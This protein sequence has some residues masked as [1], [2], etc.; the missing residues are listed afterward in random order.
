LSS[1]LSLREYIEPVKS[2]EEDELFPAR[3]PKINWRGF[4]IPALLAGY[5]AVGQTAVI[6]VVPD[7]DSFVRSMAPTSNYGAAGALSVSGSV[8]VNG[9]GQQNGLFDTLMRFPMSNV[10]A[11][12]DG[13]FGAGNWVV[14]KS[15]LIVNEMASPENAIFNRGV[16]AYEVSWI[17]S[18]GWVE[19]TGTPKTPTTDGVT[20]NDLPGIMNSNLDVS[21]GT[22]TNAGA[23]G[24]IAFT[25][26]LADAFVT[27][28]RQG[29]EVGL[30]LAAASPGVGFT[31][32][33]RDFG[34]TN[35][36]PL[37]EIT[38]SIAPR[39]EGIVLSN[40]FVEVS[41]GR[42]SNWTYRLQAS[43]SLAPSGAIHWND[44]M[45]VSAPSVA[46][47]VTYR[48]GVTNRQ[49]FYRLS[50]SP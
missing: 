7:A 41:F 8:A 40:G 31:F 37:L 11:S 22:F 21:L 39:I 29:G 49:R 2:K 45:S 10:V 6:S 14:A 44:I 4:A 23:D 48:D 28:I 36:K 3:A 17:S 42:V 13:A 15:R 26:G 9:S 25:L 16:G 50:V 19:G 20:W 34:N 30:H 12:L 43:E 5:L 1:W 18:D 47:R 32:N 27:E 35:E 38:G 33:S 24:Q 46:G